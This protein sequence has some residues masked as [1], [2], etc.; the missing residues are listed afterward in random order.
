[1]LEL[2]IDVQIFVKYSINN[3]ILIADGTY[4]ANQKSYLNILQYLIDQIS[5]FYYLN[6][7]EITRELDENLK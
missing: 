1:M 2:N 5:E 3:M 7:E 6:F 4:L